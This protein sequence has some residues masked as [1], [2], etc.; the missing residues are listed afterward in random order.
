MNLIDKSVLI[1]LAAKD[2]NEDEFNVVNSILTREGFRVFIASDANSLCIGSRGMKVRPDVSFFNMREN[3]FAAVV[4]IGGRGIKGYWNN[5]ILQGLVN[6]FNRSNKLVAAICSAPVVLSR[7][8]ILDDKEATCY[9]SDKEDL[10]NDNAKFI[11]K[12]VVFKKNIVTAQDASSAKEF[13]DTI[14]ERLR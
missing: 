2:F 6:S 14:V 11:D 10:E 1:I 12:P 7:A 9:K 5:D 13:A 4:L 8:G 3:N